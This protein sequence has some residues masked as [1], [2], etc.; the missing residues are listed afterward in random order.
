MISYGSYSLICN[1]LA[2]LA[3]LN[4]CVEGQEDFASC[5]VLVWIA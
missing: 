2:L 3:T 5:I 1:K 4:V